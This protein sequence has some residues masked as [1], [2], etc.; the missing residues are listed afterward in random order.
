MRATNSWRTTSRSV[1]RTTAMPSTLGQ[2]FE[3]LGQ[4]RAGARRQIDLGRVAGHDHARALAEPGQ[5][6]LHLHRGRVL[7]LVEDDEGARQG[8]PAHERDRRHL[9][10]AGAE[11]AGELVGRQHVVERVEDRAQIRVDLVAQIARQKAQPLAGLDR[12]PRQDD[13]LDLPGHQQVDRGGDREIGLAGAGRPEAEHQ[14]A[15]A[16]RLDIGG[17]PRRARGDAPLAGAKGGVL[18]PQAQAAV[19]DLGLGQTD[20]RLDRRQIDLLATLQPVVE[21]RQRQMGRLGRRGRARDRQPIAAGDDAKRRAAARSGRDAGRARRRAAGA[22]DCRR[23][24]AGCGLR[25][26]RPRRRPREARSCRRHPRQH[27]REAVLA[28]ARDQRRD[29]LADPLGGGGQM[30]ALQIGAAADELAAV[31]ARLFQQHRQDAADAGRVE[32]RAAAAPAAPAGS[33]SR[34]ALTGSGTWSAAAAAGVPGRGEYLN[35]NAWAKPIS[36]TRSRVARKSVV[37]LARKADDQIGGQRQIRAAPRAGARRCGGSRSRCGAGSS[38]PGR[39]R[40]RSAPADAE[41]ASAAARRDGRR[42][43]ARRHRADARWCSGCGRARRAR[44]ARGPDRRGPI[45]GRRGPRRDRR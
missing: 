41:T 32:A 20:R 30:H 19:G 9:D 21:P 43:A 7:R 22:A 44:R 16:Q 1:K 34:S 10:L 45:P 36:P 11:A 12:R 25:P 31:A 39:G 3:R 37:A 13:A 14:L 27:P 28:G 40:S 42:S 18:L 26:A 17:L 35:E 24:R 5:K 6:H 15:F 4:A 2:G 33:A 29:D 38:P 23:I 8:A